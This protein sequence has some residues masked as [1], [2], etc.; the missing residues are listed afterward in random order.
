MRVLRKRLDEG[1]L[2]ERAEHLGDPL[3]IVQ[4]HGL[5]GEVE[6]PVG[7]PGAADL[8][9]GLRAELARQ[10]HPAHGR[11]EPVGRPQLVGA[12]LDDQ[13]SVGVAHG[14]GL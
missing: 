8:R 6:P 9:S 2:P 10:V 11:A 7:T 5:L 14:G 3:E 12:G 13:V 4:G 1:I